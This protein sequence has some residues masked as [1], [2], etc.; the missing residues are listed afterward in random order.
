VNKPSE[1]FT[2]SA[3]N[4][5][6]NLDLQDL[7]QHPV[8]REIYGDGPD[9]ELLASIREKGILTPLLVTPAGGIVSG[10]RRWEAARLLKLS[11]VPAVMIEATD[12]P[13]E[14]VIL[15]SNVQRQ[16]TVAQRLR[17][18][19]RYLI[20][21]KRR[22]KERQGQRTD[23]RENSSE[24]SHARARDLAAQ[25]VG[26]S[27]GHA[28]KGLRVL[29][30]LR[31]RETTENMQLV[32]EVRTVLNESGIEAAYTKCVSLSWISGPNATA[33]RREAKP[34][35]T[36]PRQT[37]AQTAPAADG[38][39][40]FVSVDT[41]AAVQSAGYPV[42]VAAPT[43]AAEDD[44]APA[45]DERYALADGSSVSLPCGWVAAAQVEKGL[46][47]LLPYA[48]VVEG[49]H[50]A[51][52]SARLKA[53]QRFF[54]GLVER[55]NELANEAADVTDLLPAALRAVADSIEMGRD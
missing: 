15:R 17:E 6:R 31:Q 53:I 21:E 25:R 19:D 33:P 24:S 34:S 44:A 18:F 38:T 9:A 36:S 48:K 28:M 32:E 39:A 12:E 10:N 4:Q 11:A 3:V 49:E 42:E 37:C 16:K 40:P 13:I 7:T 23:L 35:A 46:D 26:W 55:V 52:S 51:V 5:I 8:S 1:S 41:A 47:R 2:T 43:P 20:I 45:T 50:R 54:L 29:H 27:G 22:A 14:E 30:V